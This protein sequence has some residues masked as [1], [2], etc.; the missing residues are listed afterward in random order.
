MGCTQMIKKTIQNKSRMMYL[1]NY[2]GLIKGSQVLIYISASGSVH[3]KAI[4]FVVADCG[5]LN[6]ALK[7]HIYRYLK[8]IALK[9]L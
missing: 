4:P 3:G 5:E 9:I 6:L 8:V 2:G 7:L 1:G